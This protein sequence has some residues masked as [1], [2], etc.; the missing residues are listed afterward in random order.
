MFLGKCANACV[1]NL[2]SAENY[3]VQFTL[4]EQRLEYRE[5]N[6]NEIKNKNLRA[7]AKTQCNKKSS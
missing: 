6:N 4:I 7:K 2:Q 5:T 1:F 3:D